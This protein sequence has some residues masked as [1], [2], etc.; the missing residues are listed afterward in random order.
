MI[1]ARIM[2]VAGGEWQCPITK[3]A[4]TMGHDVL[5][6]NLYED[7]PAFR[8]AD[9]C[10]V[11]DVLDKEKN[12]AIAKVF[13]PD[14]VLT[15]QSDI[16][17]P[18][19]AYIAQ[20]LGLK[21]IGTELA[22]KFTN[23]YLMRQAAEKAGIAS[24]HFRKC[25][26]PEAAKDFLH[27]Y[28]KSVMKPLDSQSS[29]GVHIVESGK[30]IEDCFADSLQYSNSE[31][32]VLIEEYI[33]GVEFTVDGLCAEDGYRVTAISQKE[34]F[35]H[36]PNIASRLLFS[37]EN[38]QFDYQELRRVNTELVKSMG[39]PFGQTH[40]EYKYDKGQYYLIEIAAR[41][42]GTKISSDI[43]PLVSG[44]SNNEIYI[45]TLLGIHGETE[46][47]PAHAYAVLGFFSFP[48]GRV[49]SIL[50]VEEAKTL[51]GVHDLKLDF[52]VGDILA[53]AADDRSRCGYYI[54]Y[55]DSRE[56]LEERENT[57]KKTVRVETTAASE[58]K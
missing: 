37:Q 9:E 50:G 42:G 4:K 41:G 55:A 35:A 5:C 17:V 24:P 16:A 20:Q 33:G 22:A 19:V 45:N 34:H 10:A 48:A 13:N 28:G 14:A 56:E 46:K 49:T 21:G 2:V 43:V 8:Y 47:K 30:D 36:N 44:I 18:T 53:P 29:R 54:L 31:K 51:N 3:L 58:G 27:I 38:E 1:M 12:L 7:S 32:A 23:K 26:S 11:A 39:L 6:T 57:L 40:A 25:D 15:D 52:T